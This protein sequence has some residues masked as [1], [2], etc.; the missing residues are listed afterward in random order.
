MYQ[1]QHRVHEHQKRFSVIPEEKLQCSIFAIDF[2]KCSECRL[3]HRGEESYSCTLTL[4]N[5]SIASDHLNRF[6]LNTN[7]NK[8]LINQN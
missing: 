3:S 6:Q 8:A 2:L 1:Q 7:P 4:S 5:Y